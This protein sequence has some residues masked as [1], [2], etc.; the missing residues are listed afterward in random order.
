MSEGFNDS[1]GTSLNTKKPL[2]ASLP[3]LTVADLEAS[4]RSRLTVKPT[5]STLHED[6]FAISQ[7]SDEPE[8]KVSG[9]SASLHSILKRKETD[10]AESLPESLPDS[11]K[12]VMF[13]SL[14]EQDSVDITF[15]PVYQD[16]TQP[17]CLHAECATCKCNSITTEG[18]SS[19][20]SVSMLSSN[21]T[22]KNSLAF[23]SKLESYG[24]YGSATPDLASSSLHNSEDLRV[25]QHKIR[26][27]THKH[28]SQ[29]TG[30][31]VPLSQ[32][33]ENSAAKI[34]RERLNDRLSTRLGDLIKV[35]PE[36][37]RTVK[38]TLHSYP[39]TPSR[40]STSNPLR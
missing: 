5:K 36:V 22:S 17:E 39:A 6:T 23:M 37:D 15:Q 16:S 9:M 29:V 14:P 40:A 2:I 38:S 1:T 34:F 35:R 21:P 3:G 8:V 25:F 12:H 33:L 32:R 27:L 4:P 19:L 13:D 10:I 24:L 30:S 26:N 11:E 18:I 20:K 28:V 7:T 31:F